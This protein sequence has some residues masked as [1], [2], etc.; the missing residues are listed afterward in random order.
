M[1]KNNKIF[2][3]FHSHQ[4]VGTVKNVVNFTSGLADYS[5]KAV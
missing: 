4:K 1:E 5:K 2:I 3:W